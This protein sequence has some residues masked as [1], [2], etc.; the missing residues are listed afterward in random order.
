[1]ENALKTSNFSEAVVLN[2]INKCS[3]DKLFTTF[4]KHGG[5]GGTR[6]TLVLELK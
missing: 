4:T 5:G 1:M 6:V 3:F 2:N